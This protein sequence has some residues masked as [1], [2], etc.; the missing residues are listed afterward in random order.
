MTLNNCG[1]WKTVN[2]RH[3]KVKAGASVTLL[4]SVFFSA[5]AGA[6]RWL[7]GRAR[8]LVTR[9]NGGDK[10]KWLLSVAAA[11]RNRGEVSLGRARAFIIHVWVRGSAHVSPSRGQMNINI[12][13]SPPLPTSVSEGI[14][15]LDHAQTYINI[16]TS[17]M[18]LSPA[19]V[20]FL[21]LFLPTV[22]G[23]LKSSSFSFK[24]NCAG[25]KLFQSVC[26]EGE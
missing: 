17:I 10:V 4:Q 20:H 13:I 19:G 12:T 6:R 14:L 3:A 25:I 11:W 24:G 1:I 15:P 2:G 22:C 5:T 16:L 18:H 9:Q 21:P 26:F 7:C 8:V 23:R